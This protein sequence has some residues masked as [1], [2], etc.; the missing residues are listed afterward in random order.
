MPALTCDPWSFVA[1]Q[2]IEWYPGFIWDFSIVFIFWPSTLKTSDVKTLYL[3][4]I[5]T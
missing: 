5:E 3:I 4:I 1:F 2:T